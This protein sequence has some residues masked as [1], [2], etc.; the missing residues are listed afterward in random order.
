MERSCDGLW[1]DD[2][3]FLWKTLRQISTRRRI[4]IPCLLAATG[5]RIRWLSRLG[6]NQV[7]YACFQIWQ[8]RNRRGFCWI[9]QRFSSALWIER[10]FKC[11]QIWSCTVDILRLGSMKCLKTNWVKYLNNQSIISSLFTQILISLNIQIN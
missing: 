11:L 1:Y 7:T 3:L 2:R 10:N 8:C 6:E 5:C 4:I 9:I